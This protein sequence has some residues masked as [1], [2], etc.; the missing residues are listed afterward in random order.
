MVALVRAVMRWSQCTVVGYDDFVEPGGHELQGHD[1]GEGILEG[2]AIG[3]EI[4]VGVATDGESNV[5]S[6]AGG[7]RAPFR[8]ASVAD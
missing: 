6:N 5:T 7:S 4:D 3:V 2:H 1:L 8:R